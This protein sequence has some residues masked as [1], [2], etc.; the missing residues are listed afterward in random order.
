MPDPDFDITS[1]SEEQQLA[2]QQFTSVTDSELNAA[3]PLLQKCQWNAQIAITR[4]FDGDADTVDP[5]AEA[6][7][8]PPPPPL[9]PG[10]R[11]ETLIDS[12]SPRSHSSRRQHDQRPD[13]VPRIVPTPDSQLS[14]P[15]PFPISLL[16]LPFNLTYTLLQRLLGTITYL[17][18]F[19]PRL[20][21]RFRPSP[22]PRR[23]HLNPRD[24]TA[25]FIRDFETEYN[26]SPHSNTL[27]FAESGYAQ[28]FDQAKRDLRF[29][30]VVLLSPEHDDTAQFV[31][32]TLLAPEIV[33]FLND[34]AKHEL[35][36]WAGSVQDAEAYQV[37]SGL[38]VT[39]FPYACLIVQSPAAETGSGGGAGMTRVAT[40]AGP[41]TAHD[42]LAK[43][44]EAMAKQ[45]PEL[46]G[47]RRKRREQ[48]EGRSILREQASAYER[49]LAQDR[50]K[51]RVKREELAQMEKVGREAREKGERIE[52][53]RRRREAWRRW[54]ARDIPAEPG[55]E[56]RDAVRISLR[57]LSGERVVR[58]FRPEAG[59]EEV[60]AFVEC[61]DLVQERP[62]DFSEKEPT[63]PEEGYEHDFGFR[64]VSPMPRAVYDVK[65]GGRIG[66]RI[67]RSGNLV[68]EK[69]VGEDDDD[70]EDEEEAGEER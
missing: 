53:A 61:Y 56:V 57:L 7:R 28:A 38:G 15:L 30:L 41:V 70:D 2:L 16:L 8:A 43:M 11:S 25:R 17:C 68:V 45:R 51:A 14:R 35:V 18:P 52:E 21:S 31:R 20:L 64:L 55:S 3:I 5:A 36:L 37:A 23:R 63:G 62:E 19:L 47:L 26:L 59:V 6:A 60:Y 13:T 67:G 9:Q 58:K 65:A 42:F 40:F 10:R 66:D 32:D 4:F 24:T 22:P 33:A 48:M 34:S 39:R 50:E 27:P 44:R 12:L 49:S 46:E 1:L 54:R 29:L 69:V